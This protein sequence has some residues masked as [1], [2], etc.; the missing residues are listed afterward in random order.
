MQKDAQIAL[1]ATLLVVSLAM[2]V[3]AIMALVYVNK[4]DGEHTDRR[5]PQQKETLNGLFSV[6][7]ILS[8]FVFGVSAYMLKEHA[9]MVGAWAKKRLF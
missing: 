7:L 6:Y 9:E 1:F 5:I 2:V 4:P 3:M 8:A